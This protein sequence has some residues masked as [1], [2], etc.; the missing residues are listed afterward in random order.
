LYESNAELMVK[1]GGT[2][3]YSRVSQSNASRPRRIGY[4]TMSLSRSRSTAPFG[5]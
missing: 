2:Y 1:A 5:A 3:S 4:A